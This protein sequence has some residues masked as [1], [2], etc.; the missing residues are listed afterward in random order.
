MER[1]LLLLMLAALSAVSCFKNEVTGVEIGDLFIPVAYNLGG[2]VLDAYSGKGIAGVA[3]TDGYTYTVTNSDGIYYLKANEAAEFVYYSLPAGYAS[4]T[5]EGQPGR[6]CCW[7]KADFSDGAIRIDFE[8]APL[9]ASSYTL[10][11]MEGPECGSADELS[12]WENEV[13]TPLQ[14]SLEGYSNVYA[15]VLGNMVSESGM[16]GEFAEA[17]SAVPLGTSYISFYGC[18]GESEY[19]CAADFAAEYG[20]ADY[21][22]NLGGS[23]VVVMD[24]VNGLTS[25]QLEWLKQDLMNVPNYG[26]KK[27]YLCISKPLEDDGTIATQL[28]NFATYRV[29][30]GY[31]VASGA[32]TYSTFSLK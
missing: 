30:D 6:P 24:N 11:A 3:V 20:P 21:S 18:I 26:T 7:D 17:T 15:I 5:P 23:H 12:A 19:V 28:S 10:V 2:K 22:F 13:L 8:L 14:E 27:L 4:A 32:S 1:K 16:L 29:I 31:S 25:K 9:S